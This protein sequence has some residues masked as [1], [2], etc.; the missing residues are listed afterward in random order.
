[1]RHSIYSGD[2]IHQVSFWL[3]ARFNKFLSCLV[4]L[5]YR[6]RTTEEE[7]KYATIAA[8]MADC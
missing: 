3:Q 6:R 2:F 7:R 1:L 4:F 5:V 8:L